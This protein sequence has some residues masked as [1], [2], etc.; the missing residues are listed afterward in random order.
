MQ[1]LRSSLL[2]VSEQRRKA[3]AAKT[4]TGH[5]SN[6]NSVH[7]GKSMCLGSRTLYKAL[8]IC[9]C[10]HMC[11]HHNSSTSHSLLLS[12][13]TSEAA[14]ICFVLLWDY[15][16]LPKTHNKPAA[17]ATD[18][19]MQKASMIWMHRMQCTAGPYPVGRRSL[20][21]HDGRLGVADDR[22]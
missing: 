11:C 10:I 2:V 15:A 16:K 8:T 1:W 12:V 3:G 20:G 13:T 18:L 4:V 19:L 6:P 21:V 7:L 5:R 22:S 9:A 17:S 14:V